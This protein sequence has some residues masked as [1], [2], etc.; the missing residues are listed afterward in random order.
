MTLPRFLKNFNKT[1]ARLIIEAVQSDFLRQTEDALTFRRILLLHDLFL[2][3]RSAAIINKLFFILSILFAVVVIIWPSLSFIFNDFGY[4][5]K[6]LQSAVVQ[7][8]VTALA[9]LFFSIYVHYKKY[10]MYF[11]NLMRHVFYSAKTTDEL[12]DFVT[13]EVMRIDAG[14]SF[15]EVM[16]SENEYNK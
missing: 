13:R 6:F 15:N 10:Q 14:F 16:N 3:A 8:S 1:S 11:E 4:E 2:K 7:T 9:A 12:V 5:I